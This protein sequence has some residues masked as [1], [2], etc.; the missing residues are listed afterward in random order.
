MF[1]EVLKFSTENYCRYLKQTRKWFH[2]SILLKS[3]VV[4][5]VDKNYTYTSALICVVNGNKFVHANA[6]KF[7]LLRPRI[8]S[9]AT[10]LIN[11]DKKEIW[12]HSFD[13]LFSSVNVKF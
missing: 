5:S 7:N 10:N 4:N 6:L 1:Y 13:I 8:Q 11:L 12:K 3:C 9:K 2:L